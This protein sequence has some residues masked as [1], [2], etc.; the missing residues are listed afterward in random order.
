MANDG[1]L[2][3][4]VYSPGVLSQSQMNPALQSGENMARDRA[5]NAGFMSAGAGLLA[6]PDLSS[7]LA[8]G[9]T[10]FNKAYDTSLVANRP[11]VTP[12]ADGAF[13]Q[14]SFPDG[15]VQVVENK[16]VE[17]FIMDKERVRAA[18]ALSKTIAGAEA[19][20]Q[21]GISRLAVTEGIKQ[22]PEI[23]QSRATIEELNSLATELDSPGGVK[24]GIVPGYV[25]N[26]FLPALFPEAAALKNRAERVIQ[27]GL[28]ATLGSQFTEK[29]GAAFLERAYNPKLDPQTN[30]K[31]LRRVA[32][33]IQ[34]IADN[35][36][37]AL[38]YLN[39]NKTL[40]GFTPSTSTKPSKT[41]NSTQAVDDD[42]RFYNPPAK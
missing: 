14:I 29:E 12:L 32:N 19:G 30:A 21:A 11:K 34:I 17:K 2:N 13:S 4:D 16:D 40:Q 1:I 8:A 36:E 15:T 5:M 33:E 41:S 26:A 3:P 42:E 22:A 35:R 9:L 27:N 23:A 24:T 18:A 37:A 7:G 6:A 38:E 39:K 10:G 25:P 20:A 28:R 31:S